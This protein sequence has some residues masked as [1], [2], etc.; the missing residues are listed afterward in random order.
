MQRHPSVSLPSALRMTFIQP[1]TK[2]LAEP[3]LV[4]RQ[5]ELEELMYRFDLAVKG[6]GN[7]VFVSGEAGS[8]KTRLI[9]EFLIAAK[10]KMEVTI[11]QGGCISNAAAPY[12]PFIEAFS[13]YFSK[14]EDTQ[15]KDEAE[16]IIAWLTGANQAK[17]AGKYDSLTPQAWK[18][19][20]FAA[21][22]NAFSNMSASKPMVFVI[23]DLHWADSAS[24]SLL[25]FIARAVRSMRVLLLA[26]FRSEDLTA[27]SEGQPHSLVERLLT[28]RRED[29]YSEINLSIL[30]QAQINLIVENMVGGKVSH[31]LGQE[32]GKESQGN[33]LFVVESVRM[34]LERG[35]LYKENE[36]WHLSAGI[37]EIPTKYKDI[38]LQRLNLLKLA[39]RR[40]LEAASVIGEKFDVELL[41]T[42]VGQDDLIVLEEL[43]TIAR[44]SSII[45]VEKDSFKFDHAKTRQAIYD[46]IPLPLKKGYHKRVAERL[47]SSGKDLL[48]LADIAY[49]YA[50]AENREKA[51]EF[52]LAAGKNALKRFSNA[53]AIKHY[54]YVL[55]SMTDSQEDLRNIALEGLADAY[56][57]N[58]IYTKALETF[59]ELADAAKGD[60]KLRAYRKAM[61]AVLFGRVGYPERLLKLAQKAEP[62]AA[63]NRVESARISFLR[64]SALTGKQ[65]VLDY[66][67]ALRVF[68]EEYSLADV[69]RALIPCG[70]FTTSILHQYEIGIGQTLRSIAMYQE[71]GDMH[72][73]AD[74]LFT[75]GQSFY[76]S[77]GLDREAIDR[78]AAA[79]QVGKK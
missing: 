74:A 77:G 8:G 52:S 18:D 21:V 50:Q 6:K 5:K 45:C 27:D 60:Q 43:N 3:V 12:L 79:A 78:L 28:M 44:S 41:G 24:L 49:H 26:T 66:L 40:I 9:S 7:T 47:Q 34:L 17:Q 67:A 13:S 48:R 65:R 57:A 39:Q 51:V 61:D 4:G 31:Q 55:Q 23:E 16:E 14:K 37:L 76:F 20:T 72:G 15:I 1:K 38:T 54:T 46:E 63:T 42:V 10:Q 53:Q 71:M 29:L 22:T 62:H 75:G 32:L 58:C 19:L 56:Y 35:N 70:L 69:A 33:A 2:G 36:E 73:L 25:H 30:D 59:E 11:L 68:E 64:A